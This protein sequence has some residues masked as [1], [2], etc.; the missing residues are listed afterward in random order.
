MLSKEWNNRHRRQESQRLALK[1][2]DRHDTLGQKGEEVDKLATMGGSNAGLD[3]HFSHPGE[4]P[5]WSVIMDVDREPTLLSKIKQN[6][7]SL[8]PAQ[9]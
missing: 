9:K 6:K 1:L 5:N 2:S 7:S 4:G 3:G 8:G